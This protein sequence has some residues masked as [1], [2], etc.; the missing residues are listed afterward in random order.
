MDYGSI[1]YVHASAASITDRKS[2]RNSSLDHVRLF[3]SPSPSSQSLPLPSR[4]LAAAGVSLGERRRALFTT[5]NTEKQQQRHRRVVR[6]F[7]SVFR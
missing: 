4:S 6:M 7:L 2:A 1:H 3:F 5:R